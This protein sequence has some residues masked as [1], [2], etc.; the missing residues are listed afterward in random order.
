MLTVA[1]GYGRSVGLGERAV[2][3]GLF[4]KRLIKQDVKSLEINTAT[5]WG[6]EMQITRI[7]VGK[8]AQYLP[9]VLYIYIMNSVKMFKCRYCHTCGV[10]VNTLYAIDTFVQLRL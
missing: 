2:S 9:G 3:A 5:Q 1:G 4:R 8:Y 6:F 7:K 10:G